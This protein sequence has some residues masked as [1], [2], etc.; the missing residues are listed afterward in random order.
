VS[1]KKE[2]YR[3]V[4]VGGGFG[5]LNAARNLNDKNIGVTIIDRQNH[6]L[7][8]PLLYQVAMGALS[9]ADIASPLRYILRKRKNTKVIMGEV[10]DFDPENKKVFFDNGEIAYDALV[11]AA[12]STHHYFGNDDWGVRAPGL[13]TIEDAVIIRSRV[14]RAF[15]AA[16]RERDPEAIKSA[17]T[18]VIVGGG[19]TGVE[20]AG[21][22]RE[23]A[24][25]TLKGDF[26]HVKTEESRIILVE[27][28][29]RMLPTYPERLSTRTEDRLRR[30][31]VETRTGC[32]VTGMSETEV[33]IRCG[34]DEEVVPARN[35][36]WAAG[37]KASPLGA[38][39]AEVTGA[40]IDRAGRL[41]VNNDLTLPGY[42]DIFVIGDMALCRDDRGEPLPGL[43]AVARQ[44][45]LYI[46]RA[47]KKRV[48]GK[49][50]KPF[51]YLDLGSMATIGKAAAVVNFGW[52]KLAGYIAWLIWLFVHLMY[53]VEFEN[54]LLVLFQWAWSYVT[55]NRSARLITDYSKWHVDK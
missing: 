25:D 19:P 12:G 23:I 32:L 20:L 15:E 4:I 37:V 27:G 52:L 47:L 49:D 39:L 43:A 34:A 55:G 10:R 28:T 16:E 31:G 7:F 1:R 38:R 6:H 2:T 11:V 22:L 21:A 45:G 42:P 48:R 51:R 18:F 8:Q 24:A 44:Q 50:Y 40:E 3:V 35:V 46:A 5:G 54:R 33:V 41:V 30:I 29:G 13:K 36:I 17:L 26:R 9:P 53:V 14:L